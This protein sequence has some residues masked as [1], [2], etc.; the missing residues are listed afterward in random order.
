MLGSKKYCNSEKINALSICAASSGTSS[1]GKTQHLG[2]VDSFHNILSDEKIFRKLGIDVTCDPDIRQIVFISIILGRKMIYFSTA[3]YY[4]AP[5][6]ENNMKKLTE[7]SQFQVFKGDNA[8]LIISGLA[9]LLLL[10]LRHL[11]YVEG[12]GKDFV[13]I[14]VCCG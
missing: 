11:C 7:V 10:L 4:E 6:I 3:I 2:T 12:F 1:H 13:N 8:S 9:E 5:I 14:S